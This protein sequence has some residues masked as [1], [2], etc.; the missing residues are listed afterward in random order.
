MTDPL[1]PARGASPQGR[2]WLANEQLLR[3]ASV[4]VVL[5]LW[6]I[7]GRP[8]AALITYPT[9]VLQA[10]WEVLV[11]E[12][13]LLEAFGESLYGYVI[14]YAAAMF[15]G[16]GLGF[17][18]GHARSIDI[19]LLPYVNSLYATP[20]IALI[21]LLVLWVGIGFGLRV[22]IVLLSAVFPII[23]TVREGSRR[24]ASEYIDVARSF[25]ANGWQ[26]WRTVVLPGSL[27]YLFS[28]LRIG[29]QRSLIGIVVA[30]SLAAVTGTGRM[31][32]RY[33]Q[34]FQT[35]RLLVPIL[36]IGFFSIFM[37]AAINRLQRRVAPWQRRGR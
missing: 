5:V 32:L 4:A 33:G 24:V 35:D 22:T 30:E 10:A 3:L 23:I 36:V 19:A 25:V 37:T 18:M 20:R 11:V 31:I 9:A 15:L 26:M 8:N 12:R 21:P 27:P 14:G 16:A 34:F 29:A 28:A 7:V 6:E 2:S 13:E 1:D 17:L